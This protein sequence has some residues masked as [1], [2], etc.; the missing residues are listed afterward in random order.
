MT[1]ADVDPLPQRRGAGKRNLDLF[2]LGSKSSPVCFYFEDEGSE[3]LYTR[4]LRRIFPAYEKPLVVCTGG[5]TKKQVLNDADK[6]NLSPI[7]FLQDKDFDDLI[8]SLPSDPRIVTLHRYSFENYLL[9]ADALVEIAIESKRRLRREQAIQLLSLEEYLSDLYQSYRPLAALF[10]TARRLNLKGIKTTK[11]SI[12]D[13]VGPQAIS[14]TEADV[15]QFREQVTR[16][17]L[18][19]QRIATAE[20]L[21]ALVDPALEAKSQ[22]RDHADSHP[23]AHL[24]GKHLLELALVYVDTKIGTTLSKLD[25]F[26]IAMR[27]VLHISAAVFDRVRKAIQASL[28]RQQAPADAIEFLG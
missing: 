21:Q 5:K 27:L 13:L 16:A 1:V 7:V 28:E 11:Q 10:V 24:C 9:D 15:L 4:L 12:A 8:G 2:L 3:E 26:E 20:E 18:A 6:H 19:S 22:Y 14:I 17:A 25:R 23:N